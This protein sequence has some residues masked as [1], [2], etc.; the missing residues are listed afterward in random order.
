LKNA[1]RED[2]LM[3]SVIFVHNEIG[4]IQPMKEIG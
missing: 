2:T 3:C 1:I 4:V